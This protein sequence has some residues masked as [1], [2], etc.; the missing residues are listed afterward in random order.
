V[1]WRLLDYCASAM[2]RLESEEFRVLFLDRKNVSGSPMKCSR[3]SPWITRRF[4]RAKWSSVAAR[5]ERV[6]DHPCAHHP[7]G[8]PTPFARRHPDDERR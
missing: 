7:S 5:I 2:S 1:G 3:K 4:I 6:G 8:D